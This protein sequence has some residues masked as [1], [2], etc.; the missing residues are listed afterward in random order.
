MIGVE[1]P[2]IHVLNKREITLGDKPEFAEIK[3][4]RKIS[5]FLDLKSCGRT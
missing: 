3:K 5:N 1:E 4:R 2:I